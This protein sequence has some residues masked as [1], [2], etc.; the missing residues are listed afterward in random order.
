MKKHFKICGKYFDIIL[1]V[2]VNKF[3]E[4]KPRRHKVHDDLVLDVEGLKLELG[5]KA[6]HE[7][8]KEWGIVRP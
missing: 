3:K 2:D 7:A 6:I 8:L 4:L 5:R 1:V